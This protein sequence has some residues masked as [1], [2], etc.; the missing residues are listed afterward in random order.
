M[1]ALI[2]VIFFGGLSGCDR[3]AKGLVPVASDKFP[4]VLELGELEVV[5]ADTLNSFIAKQQGTL[6]YIVPNLEG[7]EYYD[8]EGPECPE[9]PVPFPRTKWDS[10]DPEL[11][12]LTGQERYDK[13]V[14]ETG[15]LPYYFGQLG[16]PEDG[17]RGGATF[18]FK[19]TGGDVCIVVD[20]ETVFWSQSVAPDI[21]RTDQYA[22]PDKY[23]DDGDLDLFAG[24]SSYYTGSPGVEIGDFTGYY[25]DSRGQVVEIEYGACFQ[26]GSQTGM[27][28]AHA[29][30]GTPEYC[31]V[32]T[33]QKE[34]VEFTVVL[35]S[36]SL[37]VDDGV[38]S[39]GVAVV[40]ERCS[41]IDK[42]ECFVKGESL[43]AKGKSKTCTDK[44]EEAQC[45]ATLG[46]FCCANPRMCGE[47]DSV[48][49]DLCEKIYGQDD[50]GDY[51]NRDQWCL[52]TELCCSPV[53]VEGV[54]VC[55]C[56]DEDDNDQDGLVDC[57]DPG[58]EDSP[59]CDD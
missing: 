25:T 37:P 39:F 4:G 56:S 57:E 9:A 52:E 10:S 21:Q 31:N 17:G 3:N 14:E 34:G 41:R 15:I 45:N 24:M 7:P 6:A 38:L 47:E 22:Y 5:D 16:Q 8:E 48:D 26:T 20:P 12:G 30:R 43:D 55:D 50:D 53:P 13:H 40:N 23:N 2:S 32:N 42:S 35:D 54:G 49:V 36:F 46:A 29:G 33:D 28:N 59:A 1:I 58:C 18:T 51:L 27:D 19:G 44:L 11:D